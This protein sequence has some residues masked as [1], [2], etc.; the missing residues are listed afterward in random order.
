MRTPSHSYLL[1]HSFHRQ[2]MTADKQ[3]SPRSPT[4]SFSSSYA[5][6]FVYPGV[7]SPKSPQEAP[8]K[9]PHGPRTQSTDST[10]S[11]HPVPPL[12]PSQPDPRDRPGSSRTKFTSQPPPQ[13]SSPVRDNGA[14]PK[15]SSSQ[16]ASA[17]RARTPE[18]GPLDSAVPPYR[19]PEPVYDPPEEHP[20]GY[21]PGVIEEHP[22]LSD[23]DFMIKTPPA[24]S[25]SP[26]VARDVRF[27]VSQWQAELGPDNGYQSMET[28]QPERPQLGPGVMPRRLA[29]KIHEHSLFR[30][31]ELKIPS[32]KT[33]TS[34]PST[35]NLLSPN[36]TGTP[37]ASGASATLPTSPV[38]MQAQTTGTFDLD[39][40][41]T[42]QDV[43]AAL[44]GGAE[45]YRDWYFCWQCSLWFRVTFGR[46]SI[47]DGKLQGSSLDWD[48][49]PAAE[50][51][52][53]DA[54]VDRMRGEAFLRDIEQSRITPRT[55]EAHIH[56]H[57]MRSSDVEIKERP[58]NRVEKEI[59]AFQHNIPGMEVHSDW[60]GRPSP[61]PSVRLFLCCGSLASVTVDAGPVFGQIPAALLKAF[62]QEKISN[63]TVGVQNPKEGVKEAVQLLIT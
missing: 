15:P 5:N 34:H 46:A 10:S 27:D 41:H 42:L 31:S 60:L 52:G 45:G 9:H 17:D 26:A 11:A 35:S 38:P 21:V 25:S 23:D 7:R 4:G 37:A 24:R 56:F 1:P 12:S 3:Q 53:D 18:P 2:T 36:P 62:V 47:S 39:H 44:P 33:H 63:P 50:A 22:L 40:I 48:T 28:D 57:E 54:E 14:S 29:E 13:S 58:L 55:S 59:D 19:S 30:L 51:F 49:P 43:E 61:N 6:A 32:R 20:P 8:A 16:D